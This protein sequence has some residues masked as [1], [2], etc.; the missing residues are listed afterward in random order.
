MARIHL[1]IFLSLFL[2][3]IA[4]RETAHKLDWQSCLANTR[5][6]SCQVTQPLFFFADSIVEWII[7]IL[8][9][10]E[11]WYCDLLH[12]SGFQWQ[13]QVWQ[14]SLVHN[15]RVFCCGH[16]S[17]SSLLH[18]IDFQQVGLLQGCET[19]TIVKD[20]GYRTYLQQKQAT[21]LFVA[22]RSRCC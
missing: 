22:L 14:V 19:H 18:S 7:R 8:H 3:L 15:G 16:D 2:G 1:S 12:L 11:V 6:A 4:L 5:L 10:I 20:D 17:H 13:G 9:G 21:T